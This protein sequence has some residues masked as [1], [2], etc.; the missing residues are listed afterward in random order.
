MAPNEGCIIHL[1]HVQQIGTSNIFRY[2]ARLLKGYSWK[3]VKA[4]IKNSEERLETLK[5]GIEGMRSNIKVYVNVCYGD[6][7]EDS[8]IK[9]AANLG[10]DLVVVGKCAHHSRFPHLNTVVPSRI[11]QMSG[12]P[13]LTA[14]PGSRDKQIKTV[15]VPVNAHFP[16]RKVAVIKAL[17]CRNLIQIQL[18]IF[19]DDDTQNAFP[20]Q[21]LLNIFQT[22]KGQLAI[23]VKYIKLH[24]E[25]KAKALLA[26]SKSIDADMLIVHAGSETR[27]GGWSNRHMSDM[28][29]AESQTLVLAVR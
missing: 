22:L 8:I 1:L 11:A 3:Q 4:A 20:R 10:A 27:I 21:S 23:P 26:Y 19:P 25:N 15:V 17:Q 5:S 24:G 13:V 2:L 7:I 6:S 18:V 12:I 29:P 28:L 9:K 14:K 16:T